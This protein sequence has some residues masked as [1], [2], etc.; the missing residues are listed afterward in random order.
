MQSFTSALNLTL[1]ASLLSRT[2]DL[3]S[4]MVSL[5]E[6]MN[7]LTENESPGGF[8]AYVVP[9]YDPLRNITYPATLPQLLNQITWL[10][11]QIEKGNTQ[12]LRENYENIHL[13]L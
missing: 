13:N 4:Q 8:Y 2:N 3:N 6:K 10:F 11:Q 7:I 9:L 12:L 1:P 5:L